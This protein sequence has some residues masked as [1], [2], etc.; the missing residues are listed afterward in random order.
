MRRYNFY[1]RLIND[2]IIIVYKLMRTPS[3][4][5]PKD[6]CIWRFYE[7][8]L[9][10]LCSISGQK[11]IRNKQVSNRRSSGEK[12]TLNRWTRKILDSI[13]RQSA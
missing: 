1:F 10:K 5:I 8:P 9:L 12:L 3:L 2:N 11:S 13:S 4:S 7:V 6:I